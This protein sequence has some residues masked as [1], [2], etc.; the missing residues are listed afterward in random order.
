MDDIP[1]AEDDRHPEEDTNAIIADTNQW[2]AKLKELHE[3]R[4]RLL[5]DMCEVEH[6]MDMA[7]MFFFLPPKAPR[8]GW[9]T[10]WVLAAVTCDA[11]IGVVEQIIA[12]MTLRPK[13][14][15]LMT[16]VRNAQQ[17]R[18]RQAHSVVTPDFGSRF[19][20]ADWPDWILH[21]ATRK[22]WREHEANVES[23][24]Q[25]LQLTRA[26]QFGL[27]RL[28][29]AIIAVDDGED[30]DATLSAFD[31]ANPEAAVWAGVLP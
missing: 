17:A 5:S 24:K 11:K 30:V 7:I 4:G 28:L 2:M 9:F 18:N 25:D 1:G 29:T 19:S 16:K 23:L 10:S 15:S 13:M 20:K 21:Q 8:T 14:P 6:Q 31:K 3:L 27:A 12:E 22:G 26:L